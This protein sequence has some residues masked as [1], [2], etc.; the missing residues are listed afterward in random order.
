MTPGEIWQKY[1]L[2]IVL[3]GMSIFSIVVSGILLVKS[4][5]S[6]DLIQFSSSRDTLGDSSQAS[7]SANPSAGSGQAGQKVIHVDVEGG[8]RAPGLYVLPS[9]SRIDDAIAKAGGL[10][11]EADEEAMAKRLN[12]ASVLVDGAKIYVPLKGDKSHN[13]DTLFQRQQTSENVSLVNINTASA[14]ELDTL[15]GIGPVTAKKII[16][17]RPY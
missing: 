13:V 10:S 7:G 1:K 17:N 11:E 12:R 3:G 14:A 4:A 15:P 2:P 16:D 8:V 6:N 5:Q 9:A